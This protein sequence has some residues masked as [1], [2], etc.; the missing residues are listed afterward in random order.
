MEIKRQ[1]LYMEMMPEEAVE[2][3][4]AWSELLGEDRQFE[5]HDGKI[6]EVLMDLT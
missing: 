1:E 5:V 2:I 3:L 6:C 4:N